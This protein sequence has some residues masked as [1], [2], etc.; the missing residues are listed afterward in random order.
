MHYHH[1]PSNFQGGEVSVFKDSPKYFLK[2][3]SPHCGGLL[4]LKNYNYNVAITVKNSLWS[5]IP[6]VPIG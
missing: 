1:Q 5:P 4:S 6:A 3:K 2:S